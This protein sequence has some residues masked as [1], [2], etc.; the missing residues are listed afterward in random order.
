[1]ITSSLRM[2]LVL[3]VLLVAV[4]AMAL[5]LYTAVERREEAARGA[6]EDALRVARL[7]AV[8]QGHFIEGARQLLISLARLSEVRARDPKA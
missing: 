3:L 4:P 2:R 6:E 1:M 5:T 7:A 8:A